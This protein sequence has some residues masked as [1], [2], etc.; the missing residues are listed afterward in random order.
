MRFLTFQGHQNNP[1]IERRRT[2][3]VSD[4]NQ[5]RRLWI[6]GMEK[7]FSSGLLPGDAVARAHAH[8]LLNLVFRVIG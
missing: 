3:L 5:I 2:E 1:C 6:T 4:D 8:H 7:K